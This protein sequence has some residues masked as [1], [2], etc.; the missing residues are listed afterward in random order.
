MLKDM[1]GALTL[2]EPKT[3]GHARFLWVARPAK[4]DH[5]AV[6]VQRWIRSR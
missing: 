4:D 3:P 2:P 6:V 5:E 1:R